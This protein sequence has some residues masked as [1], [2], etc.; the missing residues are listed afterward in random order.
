MERETTTWRNSPVLIDG[1]GF[2]A[3][4]FFRPKVATVPRPDV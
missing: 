1:G 2:F 3:V 4:L